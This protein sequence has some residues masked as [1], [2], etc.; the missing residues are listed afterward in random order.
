MSVKP[1]EADVYKWIDR[2]KI[3]LAGEFA[4]GGGGSWVY[5]LEGYKL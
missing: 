3:E 2:A 4:N 5:V 1:R